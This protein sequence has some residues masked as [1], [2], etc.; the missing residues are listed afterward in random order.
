MKTEKYPVKQCFTGYFLG[1]GKVCFGPIGDEIGVVPVLDLARTVG[2]AIDGY[3]VGQDHHAVL[4]D[5]DVGLHHHAGI[6]VV[7]VI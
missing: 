4:G 2:L 5:A 6:G 7:G 1:I 3:V